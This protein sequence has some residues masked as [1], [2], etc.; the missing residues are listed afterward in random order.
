MRLSQ[1]LI[2]FTLAAVVLPLSAVG[3]LALRRTE[4]ALADRFEREQRALT[5]AAAERTASELL[6]VIDGLA[7]SAKLI[8]WA[9]ASDDEV[10]G[11]LRLLTSQSE[12][13]AAVGLWRGGAVAHVAAGGEGHPPF[14]DEETPLLGTALPLS[15][16]GRHGAVGQSVIGQPV[17]VG[18]RAALPVAVQ[19]GP[20]GE[21]PPFVVALLGLDGVVAK[22]A[23]LGPVALIDTEHRQVG[24]AEALGPAP[25]TWA[26]ATSGGGG[27]GRTERGGSVAWAP[28]P[29][30]LGLVAVLERPEDEVEG[31]V[32]ALRRTVLGGVVAALSLLVAVGFFFAGRFT[33]RIAQL[34]AAANAFGQGDLRFRLPDGSADELGALARAFNAMG[35][36]LEAARARLLQWN[37]ELKQRVDLAT[38][39]LRAAQA[40]LL[41]AEKL[42]A[43]GQLGAGVA[44]EINNP[45]VGILGNAQLLLLEHTPEDADFELLQRIEES[46][47]RCRDITQTLL[48]FSQ[49]QGQLTPAEVDLNQVLEGAL[50]LERPR[51]A[52]ANVKLE[53]KL[54]TGPLK[55]EGDLEA[56]IPVVVQLCTNA[57]TAMRE[58]P[59]KVLTL[60][61]AATAEGAA[62]IVDDTGKGIA[63]E[64][65]SRVFEPFFTTK[66]VWSNLG[67]GLSVAYRVVTELGGR[68]EVKSSPGA[69]ARFEVHLVRFDPTRTRTPRPALTPPGA[70]GSGTGLVR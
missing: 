9:D 13:V 70:K 35:Q 12:L 38:A 66:D 32:R 63:P 41:E 64:H 60:V 55:V 10:A 59:V 17:R 8:D 68:I 67:L 36:E 4:A 23:G 29:E 22:L 26:M 20:P 1:Q 48:R 40:Q 15:T 37:D 2:L 25:S 11:G 54:A 39:E 28:V 16:L 21:S 56:L 49:T 58:S 18:G 6:T 7:A 30:Q 42:A 34:E 69:G 24:G 45:L 50:A 47:K 61:T 65:L 43:I 33:A 5:V 19:V 51:C 46:A 3:F 27:F 57:R 14:D 53:V 52:E 31:P 62:V 44:H